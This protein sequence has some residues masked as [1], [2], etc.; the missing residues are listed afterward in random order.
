MEIVGTARTKFQAISKM[1]RRLSRLKAGSRLFFKK[2][3]CQDKLK[4]IS[5]DDKLKFVLQISYRHEGAISQFRTGLG[6]RGA[7]LCFAAFPG[8]PEK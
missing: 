2:G 6:R 1:K 4:L 5:G 3:C 7:T 8:E